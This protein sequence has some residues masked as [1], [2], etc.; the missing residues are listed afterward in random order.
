MR[1]YPRRNH[2]NKFSS[3]HYSRAYSAH[4]KVLWQKIMA[5]YE[6]SCIYQYAHY[7]KIYLTVQYNAKST[8]KILIQQYKIHCQLLGTQLLPCP[9]CSEQLSRR[10]QQWHNYWSKIHFDTG[11]IQTWEIV[12]TIWNIQL[13]PVPCQMHQTCGDGDWSG[14]SGHWHNF[15]SWHF[16]LNT[17]LSFVFLSILLFP[18]FLFLFTDVFTVSWMVIYQCILIF[19]YQWLPKKC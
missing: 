10:I 15:P 13:L 18:S 14:E 12:S 1:P 3:L 19:F 7:R 2:P 11:F 6:P 4:A 16:C 17:F 8:T 5:T 9:W